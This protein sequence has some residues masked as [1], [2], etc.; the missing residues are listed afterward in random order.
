MRAGTAPGAGALACDGRGGR[1]RA[2]PC[3]TSIHRWSAC[4]SRLPGWRPT[5]IWSPATAARVPLRPTGQVGEFVGAVR[6]RA[7]Q[8]A[9]ALHP[10]IG[11]HAPLTFDLFDYLDEALAGRLPVSC[12]PSRRL[13]PRA[14]SGQ[15]VRSREPAIGKRF[16][17]WAIVRAPWRR[18]LRRSTRSFR[19]RSICASER[20]LKRHLET[21]L[22]DARRYDELLDS[23][24]EC[25]RRTGGR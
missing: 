14:I 17:A 12:H 19:S 16:F 21:Y 18:R 22:S 24:G 25:A 7:W 6:Y 10:T 23:S 15:F 8:P 20:W 9:S 3:A 13:E 11:V 5:A 1:A 4:R 2:A